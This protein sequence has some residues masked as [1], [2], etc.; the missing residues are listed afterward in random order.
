MTEGERMPVTRMVSAAALGLPGEASWLLHGTLPASPRL[1]VVGSRAAQRVALA[2][3]PAI[4][5]AAKARGHALVSGGA[6]GIDGAVHRAALACGAPQLA[7]L[8]CGPDAPYP[9]EHAGLFAAIA[10]APGSG[11]LFT[12]PV[13]ASPS[14]GVFTSRNALVVAAARAVLVAQAGTRSGSWGTGCLA[15]RR[16][17]PTA[18]LACGSGCADLIARGAHGLAAEPHAVATAV[19]AWLLARPQPTVWPSELRWLADALAAAGSRGLGLDDLDP[20][21]GTGFAALLSAELLGLIVESPPG[22]YHLRR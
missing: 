1:A 3:V 7:I 19:Q 14:R 4:V 12:R 8:P 17:R 13:G 11:V 2:C 21:A 10:A 16:G 5:E 18:A 22:R 15:L 6:R 9:P 20:P